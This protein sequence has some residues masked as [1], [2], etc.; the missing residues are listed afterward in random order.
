VAESAQQTRICI[1]ATP[2]STV[3][4]VAGL[5]ETFRSVAGFTDPAER[6]AADW[7]PFD[8]QIVS[9]AAG[10]IESESGLAITAHRS[11]DDVAETD[12]VIVPSMAFGREGE[13][14]PGHY[15]KLVGWLRKMHAGGAT[16]C[17]ACTGANLTAEAGLLD[18]TEAT[19]HWMAENSFRRR[20]PEVRL[21]PEQVLVISGDGGRIITSGAA[22]AWHDL[23]LHL[24]ARHVGPA[25]AH[26]MARYLMF[27]WHRDGQ[28]PFQVFNPPIDHDDAAILAAQR[29][30]AGSFAVAA[31]VEEM[32]K[33]SGLAPR[34]FKRRFKVATSHTPIDYVQRVRVERAK[35]LLETG[36]ESVEQISWSV[37]YEDAA[38]F[39]RLFKRATGLTPGAY[40]QRF[41]IP[42]P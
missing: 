34:T 37:G 17:S 19:V 23:A 30:I 2:D 31:P 9:E 42:S 40:R 7:D 29:G 22:S 1:V 16:I 38:S 12:V 36:H 10:V 28:A 14:V 6:A 27:E 32:I 5:F 33:W 15:P 41:R 21:R 18:G 13:W 26:A 24:I 11:V 8:V 20:H 25:T 39:R 3:S 4:P 35:R